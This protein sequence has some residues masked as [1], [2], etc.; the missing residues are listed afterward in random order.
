MSRGGLRRGV[1]APVRDSKSMKLDSGNGFSRRFSP[2]VGQLDRQPPT[3]RSW[4]VRKA[5]LQLLDRIPE[6]GVLAQRGVGS[7][8]TAFQARPARHFPDCASWRIA[9][10]PPYTSRSSSISCVTTW[11]LIFAA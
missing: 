3:T 4:K 5:F 9:V 2:W 8:D 6:S 1:A 11:W 7:H 10:M